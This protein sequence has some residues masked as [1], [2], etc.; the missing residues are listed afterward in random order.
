MARRRVG[1]LM[2]PITTCT[3]LRSFLSL[4]GWLYITWNGTQDTDHEYRLDFRR[5]VSVVCL[6]SCTI[7]EPE[8]WLTCNKPE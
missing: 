3:S 8:K 7:P 5:C 4:H 1:G 6:D 2:R